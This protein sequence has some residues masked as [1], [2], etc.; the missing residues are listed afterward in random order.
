MT[1]QTLERK[2]QPWVCHAC[3]TTNYSPLSPQCVVCFSPAPSAR[4]KRRVARRTA[5]IGGLVTGAAFLGSGGFWVAEYLFAG[6][7]QPQPGQPVLEVLLDPG[8][9][10]SGSGDLNSPSLAWSPDGSSI[11]C[12]AIIGK[13]TNKGVIVVD[14]KSAQTRWTHQEAEAWFEAIAWSPDGTQLALAGHSRP[15]STPRPSF[16][17]IWQVQGWQKVAEYPVSKSDARGQL[18]CGQLAWSPDGTRLAGFNDSVDSLLPPSVQIWNASDGKVLFHQEVPSPGKNLLLNWLPDGHALAISWKQGELD[19]WDVRSGQSLFHH[20]QDV[21]STSEE[22]ASPLL[23]GP[24]AAISPDGQRAAIYILEQG[25]LVIQ[26]WDLSTA[27]PLF[28]CQAVPGYTGGLTW[29]P[30]GRYL[31]ACQSGP[32]SIC[33]WN[34]DTGKLAFSND[35]LSNPERLTWSPNGRFLAAVNS[36][37]PLVFRGSSR[38]TMLHVLPIR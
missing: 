34:A 30:D 22:N 9:T 5:L 3:G 24:A 18:A 4:E 17:Q 25:Q 26:V 32:S 28:R 31:A 6:R 11:A 16:I 38:N 29:S 35:A 14:A 7:S 21:P 2:P 23:F 13:S 27:S 8:S 12:N 33:F 37:G 15:S 20:D 19:I 10:L 1:R 36:Q